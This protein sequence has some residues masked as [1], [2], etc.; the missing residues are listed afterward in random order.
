MGAKAHALNPSNPSNRKTRAPLPPGPWEQ[1]Y[2]DHWSFAYRLAQ[3]LSKGD[4][5]SARRLAAGAFCEAARQGSSEGAANIA[6][7]W[8]AACLALANPAAEAMPLLVGARALPRQQQAAFLA[9]D[10]CGIEARQAAAIAGASAAEFG[11]LLLQARLALR[12]ALR[13]AAS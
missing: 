10:I 7:R 2:R 9:F 6:Q 3:A 11:R 4:A 13:S 12:G 8:A 1:A 5:A